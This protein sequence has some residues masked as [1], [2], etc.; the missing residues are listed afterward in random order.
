MGRFTQPGRLVV[1]LCPGL[2][3]RKGVLVH[4]HHRLLGFDRYSAV[5]KYHNTAV[6]ITYKT[7]FLNKVSYITKRDKKLSATRGYKEAM[8]RLSVRTFLYR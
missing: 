3:K 6:F 7:Q 2:S 1:D 5:V 8:K 4:Q